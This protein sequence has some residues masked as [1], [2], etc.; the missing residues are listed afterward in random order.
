MDAVPDEIRCVECGGIANR[1]S[2]PPPDEDFEPGDVVAY[3]CGECGHRHDVV[4]D[5][6]PMT[7][8]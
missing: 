2:Y 5:D 6:E 1:M 4:V 3:V 8:E 7:R